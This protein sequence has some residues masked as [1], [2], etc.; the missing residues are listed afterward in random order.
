M[1]NNVIS[2]WAL[3]PVITALWEAEVGRSQG[4]EFQTSSANMVKPVSIKNSKISQA[5]CHVPVVTPTREA[6]S[7]ELLEPGRQKLQ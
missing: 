7:E 1:V 5:C 4:Q 2:D 3:T 6:E